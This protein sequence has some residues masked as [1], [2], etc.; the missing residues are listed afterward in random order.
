MPLLAFWKTSVKENLNEKP[1]ERPC[2]ALLY[3][4]DYLIFNLPFKY[5]ASLACGTGDQSLCGTPRPWLLVRLY[6]ET[7]PYPSCVLP[8]LPKS[9]F[10]R[11]PCT[12]AI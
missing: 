4:F 6:T 5:F 9:G 1:K 2:Q 3:V 8:I 11:K 10:K 12:L 7:L